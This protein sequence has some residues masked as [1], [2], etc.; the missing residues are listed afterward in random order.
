MDLTKIIKPTLLL[1]ESKCRNNIRSM[2]A[3]ARN[4]G[5][6][7]RPHFKT[8]QS[9]TIGNWFREEGIKCI[10]VSSVTMGKHFADDGWD[11]ITIA[12]P[13]NLRE[14]SGLKHIA[15][16][17]NVNILVSD[18]SQA[19]KLRNTINFD[20][21]YYIKINTGNNRSGIDWN[22]SILQQR[23]VNTLNTNS[24]LRFKGFLTHTGHTYKA[25]NISEI[26]DI[27][28]DTLNKFNSIRHNFNFS[29]LLYSTG[30]TPSCS[31][32]TDFSGFNEVRPGNFVFYDITQYNLGSCKK[33]NIAVAVACPVV[34]KNARRREIIIY[35]GG[36]H[37]SKESFKLKDGRVVYGETVILNDNDWEFLPGSNYVKSLSQEHG[38]IS[39]SEEL[40]NKVETGDLL[41]ILPVHSCMTADLLR[42]YMTFDGKILSDFSPK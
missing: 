1:D 16:K 7:F 2:A 4:S 10:T 34:E 26:I 38:I 23:I 39:A 41:G 21:G 40:F 13:F 42:Q 30:D 12:F 20:S 27:Y 15:G 28:N 32:V 33:E 35:G 6:I 37:L 31:L 18:L 14:I 8:H 29:D 17:A 24:H 9:L 11:D 25:E 5:V 3:K 19:E 36:V 22:E